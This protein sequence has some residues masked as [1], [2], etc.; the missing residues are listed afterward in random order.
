MTYDYRRVFR[1]TL[2]VIY[3]RKKFNDVVFLRT[4]APSQ[5]ENGF[6]NEGGNC[7]QRRPFHNNDPIGRI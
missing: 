6:W 1:T 5:L 4:F 2:K 3:G 7:V